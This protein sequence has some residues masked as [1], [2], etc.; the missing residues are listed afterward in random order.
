MMQPY[1]L[2]RGIQNKLIPDAAKAILLQ[3]EQ[4]RL[5]RLRR[6]RTPRSNF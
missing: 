1:V 5:N 2:I 3:R 6:S 4:G